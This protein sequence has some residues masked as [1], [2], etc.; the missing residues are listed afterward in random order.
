MTIEGTFPKSDGDILYASEINRVNPKLIGNLSQ[1]GAV[2]ISGGD[3]KIV[4]GSILYPGTGSL[5]ISDFMQ[6][7]HSIYGGGGVVNDTSTNTQLRISGTDLNIILS[8][9]TIPISKVYGGTNAVYNYILTSGTITSSGGNI[10]TP[11]V[12]FLEAKNDFNNDSPIV[13]DFS[14]IGY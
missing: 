3:Y 1:I 11:Y 7:Q 12:F 5:Q 9:K 10:G 6:I 4:G 8:S 2:N 14:V 13:F